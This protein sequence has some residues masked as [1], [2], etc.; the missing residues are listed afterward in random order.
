MSRTA[1]GKLRKLV[2]ELHS[3]D[4][5]T[6]L[7]GR[8][9]A[10]YGILQT[11]QRQI[12]EKHVAQ[13]PNS[14]HLVEDWNNALTEEFVDNLRGGG[15]HVSDADANVIMKQLQKTFVLN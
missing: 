9:A 6:M 5:P 14:Q 7:K 3:D 10:L 1:I 11:M 2:Q 4:T 13:G 8:Y 15:S 12:P